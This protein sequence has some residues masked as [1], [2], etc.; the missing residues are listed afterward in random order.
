[1]SHFFIA[2]T[3]HLIITFCFLMKRIRMVKV[4]TIPFLNHYM[5]ILGLVSLIHSNSSSFV[6]L[7]FLHQP[8][9]KYLSPIS[10]GYI[11]TLYH[12]YH[13]FSKKKTQLLLPSLSS[14]TLIFLGTNDLGIVNLIHHA[15]HLIIL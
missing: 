11:S 9:F 1:M 8:S 14:I 7:I 6:L 15:L 4:T 5:D 10:L 13:R 2:P 12:L 3:F